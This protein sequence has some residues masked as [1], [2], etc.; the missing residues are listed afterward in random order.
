MQVQT[1]HSAPK[2]FPSLGN[3]YGLRSCEKWKST[4]RW[5]WLGLFPLN[6]KLLEALL[7]ARSFAV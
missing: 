7:H 5:Y 4:T 6:Y 1:T 2:Q 3:E